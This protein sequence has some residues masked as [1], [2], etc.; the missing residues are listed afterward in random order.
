MFFNYIPKT[1][2]PSRI[3]K[4]SATVIDHVNTSNFLGTDNKQEY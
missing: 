4:T 1:L 2:K 3:S